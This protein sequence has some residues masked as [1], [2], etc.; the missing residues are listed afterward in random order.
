MANK[1]QLKGRVLQMLLLLCLTLPFQAWAQKQSV[2]GVITEENGD[3][4]IGATVLEKGTTNGV[5]TDLDG[6]F[7][8]NVN[9]KGTLVVSYVGFATQ[10]IAVKGR[11]VINLTL[12]EDTQFLDELVVVGYGM[13]KKSD[14]T[15]AIS[16]VNG[17]DLAKRTT[18]NPAEALQG[19]IAG[20]NIMKAGGNAGAGI[21]VKIR[22]VKTFGDN[23][24]LYII[25][26]FPGDINSVNP[27]DIDSMEVLKD[28]AA[29]AIYGSVA[30]NGVI[31]IT[32]KNGKK[33]EVKVDFSA[34]VSFTRIAN[35]FKMLNA[36]EYKQ[37]HGQMYDNWN[38]HVA[39]HPEMYDASS[40]LSS[41]AYITADT[42]VNT[43]WQ[44]AM[45]RSGLTQNYM[46]SVRGGGDLGKY[47]VSYNH[48]DEKGI[49]LGNDYTM[50]NARVKLNATKYIFDFEA[51]MAFKYTKSRQP[52]YQIK[53]MYG[54]SPLVPVYDA[55]NEYGYGL[56]DFNGLPNNRNVMADNNFR[57]A[58]SR[59]YHTTA[60]AAITARFTPWLSFKTSYAYRGEHERD[61][62]HTAPYVADIR[63]K[64]EY[65]ESSETTAYWEEH[66]WEN[67]LSFNKEFG[68]HSVNAVAGTSTMARRYTWNYVGVIG[69][70]ITYKVEDGQLVTGEQPG[71]FLDPDFSTIGAGT[72]GTYDGD[73]S[74]WDYRRFSVFG[75][76]NYNF[77]NHYLFQATVRHDGSSKFGKDKR[78]GTF[79]SVAVGWR[80]SEESFFPKT[81]AFN[82][83]KLRAS[84]GRLGNEN[85]LGYYDF[86][87][88]ISTYNSKNQGYVQ[89]NGDNA[90]AGSIARG[91]ENR[92][93]QWET[94]D[95]KNIGIDYGFFNN[96]LN[97]S[98]NYYYNKTEDLLITKVLPP[99]AGLS[100]PILNVGKMRNTGI[101]FEINY[102]DSKAGWDWNIGMNLSTTSNKVLELSDENQ[103]I[104]GEG[105]KF[106]TEHFPT[107]TMIGKPIGSFYLFRTDGIFQSNEEAANYVN[108]KGEKLQPYADA[109]DI[110]FVDVN[111][112]GVIDEN[113]KEYCGSGIPK[114]EVNLNLNVAWKGFDLM[115]VLGSAFNYKIYN[116]N[117]Y[118][119]ESMN[120]GSN[121]LATTLDAWTPENRNTTMPRAIFNDPNG[122][123]KESDRFLENGSFLRL[124]Q[125]QLGYTVPSSI[126]RKAYIENLR[127]YVSAENLFTITGYKGVDPEFSRANVLNTGIDRLI[128]PFTRSF[129]IG[130]Q[131]TF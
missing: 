63:S 130:V 91:L 93:L 10:E 44:D 71:G 51:N 46:L 15:G 131:L 99:S 42:G 20:V 60:N 50:D 5:S 114:L 129:T 127:F 125:L 121:V 29:A 81:T 39:L 59:Y 53:E 83:L 124:R 45:T 73:G 65:P 7:T 70:T 6:K 11:S 16:S 69:K 87:S 54:I 30:A 80:I 103:I 109:G 107:Q 17:D 3:P 110:R 82:N 66:V 113:D 119:Y 25:D 126:T 78:W 43:D 92:N 62:Y 94:T 115:A 41:P 22:G 120:A 105:L 118:L 4:V 58:D 37:V 55:E 48:S 52:Q 117:R 98:F 123:L 68:K 106:G 49:F 35:K 122:N 57:Q 36:D 28:G 40:M 23:E 67:V 102:Q 2:T 19:K 74:R 101:E 86:L 111:G 34:Y 75:R 31:I 84:W 64:Q 32:T 76:V 89:G 61:K 108:S 33:G 56:T 112:D 1:T 27:Q 24:P 128:Y 96:R 38:E 88:L 104:Y 116:G 14:M 21:Q 47:S 18:T 77:D 85:A 79:P 72:G 12:K 90:W 13:M 8:L 95:T 26:G 9:P 97:G 100:N